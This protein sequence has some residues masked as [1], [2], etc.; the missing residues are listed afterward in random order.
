MNFCS[1]N[2][3]CISAVFIPEKKIVFFFFLMCLFPLT[4]LIAFFIYS[5]RY[6]I[7]H[8][9]LYHILITVVFNV[10]SDFLDSK[11]FS[12]ESWDESLSSGRATLNVQNRNEPVR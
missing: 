4:T 3:R 2:V 7:R 5:A 10:C 11:K 12:F 9:A 6:H 8:D 1:L